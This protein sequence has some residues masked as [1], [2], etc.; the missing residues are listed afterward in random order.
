MEEL[1]PVVVAVFL[2]AAVCTVKL[3][4]ASRVSFDARSIIA[5]ELVTSALCRCNSINSFV[6]F[7]HPS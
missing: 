3:T 6:N 1:T 7:H 2:I 4:V 5:A